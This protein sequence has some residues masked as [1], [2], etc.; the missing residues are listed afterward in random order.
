MSF[1]LSDSSKPPKADRQSHDFEAYKMYLEGRY[2][3]NKRTEEGLRRSIELFQRATLEDPQYAAAYAGLADAYALLGSYGVEPAEQAYPSARSAALNAIRLDD[4]MPEAYASLG[5]ISFYY[6][7]NW[8]QAEEDFRHSIQ[9]N[10]QYALAHTWYA[11]H[12]AAMGRNE[13]AVEQIQQAQRLNPL[14]LV[15]NTELGRVYYLVH[16]FEHSIQAY[17]RVIDL[18]PQFGRAHARLGMAY[19]AVGKFKDAAAE[20]QLA[21]KLSG[22]DPYLDGLLGY[23]LARSG[24]ITNAEKLLASCSNV[25]VEDLYRLSASP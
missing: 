10:P 17:R 4:S 16:D 6:E 25:Q 13:E 1:R 21:Q 3:W 19:L 24:Q 15:T 11:V 20:F 18:E 8:R 7:W 2:F 14:S 12:L 9:L 23:A 22:S 5:M